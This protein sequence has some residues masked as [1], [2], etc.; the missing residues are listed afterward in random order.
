M[1][2]VSGWKFALER[3]MLYCCLE[4]DL[5][6]WCVAKTCRCLDAG[7]LFLGLFAGWL[8]MADRRNGYGLPEHG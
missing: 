8:M 4:K 2:Y 5:D 1:G 6:V 7:I 3:K